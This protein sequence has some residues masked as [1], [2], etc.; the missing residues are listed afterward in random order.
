MDE[1]EDRRKVHDLR[2]AITRLELFLRLVEAPEEASRLQ[3]N[4][5]QWKML[6][7]SANEA[8]QILKDELKL[9]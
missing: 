6:V 3:G 2:G 4:A 5:E 7:S 8:V 1:L 9:T